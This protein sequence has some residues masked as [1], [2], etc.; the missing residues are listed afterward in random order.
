MKVHYQ[1]I[2]TVLVLLNLH[3]SAQEVGNINDPDGYTNIRESQKSSSR[4]LAKLV[5][6]ERFL[7][8]PT[9]KSNWWKVI[10][11][12][13]MDKTIEGFVHKSRIQ[14]IYN[15][16][17]NS[18][19]RLKKIY[20]EFEPTA[21]SFRTLKRNIETSNLPQYYY[22]ET[23]DEHGRV[24]DLRFIENGKI[25]GNHLCYLTPWI[26][27]EYPDPTT[28]ISYNLYSDGSKFSSIECEKW[29]KTT[30]K[31]NIQ[32]SKILK[33]EIEYS[34]DTSAYLNDY[35]WTKEELMPAL[36]KLK[37]QKFTPRFVTGFIK[38]TAKL[39]GHFPIGEK[40]DVQTYSYTGLEFE[41]IKKLVE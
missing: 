1:I 24:I 27:F 35:G 32:Q 20:H 6:G 29:Y 37:S 19:I 31:I 5:S 8:Y 38:S 7:Y 30:Y 9:L 17:S 25:I 12:V 40:F 33:A 36:E 26:K 16:I 28:I 14:P 22:I 2:F 18:N 10:K 3:V 41:E 11:K 13:N 39:N 23:V 21:S 15:P 4:I 34:I